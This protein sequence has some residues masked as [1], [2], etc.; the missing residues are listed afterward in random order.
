MSA[1]TELAADP[2]AKGRLRR[3]APRVV[4]F[5]VVM[6]GLLASSGWLT[7]VWVALSVGAIF[8]TARDWER[9]WQYVRT[10]V[11]PAD[12]L[13]SGQPADWLEPGPFEVVL[14]SSGSKKIQLIKQIRDLTGL[15]LVAAKRLVDEPPSV[16]V[17]S[18]SRD[19]AQ[20]AKTMLESAGASATLRPSPSTPDR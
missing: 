5:A 2:S 19:S 14:E 7:Y 17:Q 16:A 10:G 8:S 15:D 3:A 18:V 13:H 6:T 20:R 9:W 4:W 12:S 1:M 11:R